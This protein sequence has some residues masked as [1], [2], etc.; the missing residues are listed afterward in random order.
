VKEYKQ[1]I[2]TEISD[3]DLPMEEEELTKKHKDITDSLIRKLQ[4][5]LETVGAKELGFVQKKLEQGFD[6]T[7]R[8]KV[9]MNSEKGSAH[10]KKLI[11]QFENCLPQPN[12]G[13]IGENIS[14][15][16]TAYLNVLKEKYADFAQGY[17]KKFKAGAA[18]YK[19]FNESMPNILLSYF[20]KIYEVCESVHEHEIQKIKE[21]LEVARYGEEKLRNIIATQEK[22]LE[23]TKM[24]K[25]EANKAWES[26]DAEYQK[27]SRR[28]NNR[29]E[30]LETTLSQLKSELNAE[31]TKHTNLLDEFN[32]NASTDKK[33]MVRIQEKTISQENEIKFLKDRVAQL[34]GDIKMFKN[35]NDQL[36]DSSRLYTKSTS[37][38]DGNV[39]GGM[40]SQEKEE[41]LHHIDSLKKQCEYLGEKAKRNGDVLGDYEENPLE[42]SF[43]SANREEEEKLE[44]DTSI[45]EESLLVKCDD[46]ELKQSIRVIFRNYKKQKRIFERRTIQIAGENNKL[47]AKMFDLKKQV[48]DSKAANEINK[49]RQDNK[50][51]MTSLELKTSQI[52]ST[53]KQIDDKDKVINAIHMS[54]AEA[55]A[56]TV[57]YETEKENLF[58]YIK[59]LMKKF[60]SRENMYQFA[61]NAL[62][63]TD[64]DTITSIKKELGVM[65]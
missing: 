33:A 60:C 63:E 65:L 17:M 13:E 28:M 30:E 1:R 59:E 16:K 5:S 26:L 62:S 51:M 53:I 44:D 52:E 50:H 27:L 14:E 37:D 35:E 39:R 15:I 34:E 64:Q 61:F 21:I 38:E 18:K 36:R 57:E 19:V 11:A 23:D 32:N 31:K 48:D 42:K 12:P 54:L 55:K 7:F 20:S 10:A 22:M 47:K 8:H 3:K 45:T 46:E 6:T 25:T 9:S 56:K 2:E 49:L 40:D 58:F 43:A 4:S 24:A 29:T 41:L